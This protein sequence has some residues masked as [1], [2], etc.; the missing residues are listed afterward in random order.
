MDVTVVRKGPCCVEGEHEGLILGQIAGGAKGIGIAGHGMRR[1]THIRP[2]D[3]CS[4]GDRQ[5]RWRKGIA[6][7]LLNDLHLDCR[8]CCGR[9]WL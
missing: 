7:I 2:L 9:G 1:V 3:R 4:L 5:R 6:A 8:G